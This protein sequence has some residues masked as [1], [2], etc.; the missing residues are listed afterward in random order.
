[1]QHGSLKRE[2]RR[3]GPDVWSFRWRERKENGQTVLRRR[4]IGNVEKYPTEADVYTAIAETI[5]QANSG[6]YRT[7]IPDL[8]IADLA[9]HFKHIELA[10]DNDRRSD[11]TKSGYRSTLKKW[12]VPKWGP[13][14]VDQVKA[15]AVESWLRTLGLSNGSK[16]KLR[17]LLHQL[18]THA[19]RYDLYLYPGE[20][21][22][23]WVRQ[24]GQRAFEPD[25]LLPLEVAQIIGELADREF[26]MFVIA[27]FTALRRSEIFGLKWMDID[28]NSKT[29]TVR[30]SLV[31]QV[32]G[33]CKTAASMASVPLHA[34]IEAALVK[35]REQSYYTSQEDWVFASPFSQ[36]K[37]PFTSNSPIKKVKEIARMLGI[38]KRIGWHTFRH[39]FGSELIDRGTNLRVVQELM[40]HR[41]L[42]STLNIYTRAVTK[43]KRRA[44]STLIKRVLG[45]KSAA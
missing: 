32:E 36:G 44:Q 9:N 42:T 10:P 18:Y 20:N 3:R 8:T 15:P 27:A 31:R 11:S 13:C 38:N 5:D 43:S 33:R 2:P 41:S 12:I 1:M 28:F 16:R 37:L 19:F 29:I 45:K 25:V 4:T 6:A 39:T 22:I 14:R 40:R 21:P 7:P 24:S 23:H 30:R 17:D 34:V 35:W 26:A